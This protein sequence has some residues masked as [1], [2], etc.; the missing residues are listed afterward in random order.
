M[1]CFTTDFTQFSSTTVKNCH[2]DGWLGACLQF[3]SPHDVS[4]NRLIFT[5]SKSTIE[6]P[7]KLGR[8]GTFI[9]NFEHISHLFSSVPMFEFE[10]VS[11]S[12]VINM[13]QI[14]RVFL[15]FLS[16][17]PFRCLNFLTNTLWWSSF[18]LQFLI[19]WT[20]LP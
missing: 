13:K 5:C 18:M 7:E 16:K 15:L 12:W 20:C 9:V 19:G 11:V 1:E 2:F 14:M 10:Q 3:Q 17:F 6:A 4:W 8:S